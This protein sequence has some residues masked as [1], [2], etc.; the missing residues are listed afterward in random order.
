M[1]QGAEVAIDR[2]NENGGL[3]G[4]QIETVVEDTEI[5]PQTTVQKTKKLIQQDDA[6]AIFGPVLSSSRQ[7]MAPVLS[8]EEVPGFYPVEYEGREA[9]DYCND[10][11]FKIGDVP[12]QKIVPLIPWLLE[13]HGNSFYLLGS[14]YV[15][16]HSMNRVIKREL[17]KH[18]GETIGEEYISLGSTDVSSILSRVESADPDI[19]FT[20]VT[21]T[22]SQALQKQMFNRGLRENWQQVGLANQSIL[23]EGVPDGAIEGCLNCQP[24]FENLDNEQN[25][26]FVSAISE[27]FDDPMIGPYTGLSI[28]AINLLEAG[29][30]SAGGTSP[31]DIVSGVA[32]ASAQTPMGEVS[33]PYDTQIKVSATVARMNSNVKYDP[34]K[35]FDAVMPPE[36]CN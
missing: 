8:Q 15:W 31:D 23:M 14:D 6:D 32:G 1:I 29:V 2:I 26:Q 9:N 4:K 20:E 25:E 36:H 22:T 33:V 30:N 11:L 7:A 5:D 10:W 24:Y 3:N 13:N 35:T 17:N 27:N 18:G 16:P 34:I 21:S 28:A 12:A 19:L